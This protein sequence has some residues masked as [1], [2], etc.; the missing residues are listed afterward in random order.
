MPAPSKGPQSPALSNSL[1]CFSL[2][3]DSPMPPS[4]ILAANDAAIE[5]AAESLQRGEL[6]AFPTET[7]YGL[8]ANARSPEAIARVFAAKGR[9]AD[10]PLIV[11]LGGAAELD[12]WAAHVP[13]SAMTL[14][15]AFW[16]GPLTMILRRAEGVSDAITGGQDTVGLRVP[17]H[18]VALR[19]L[20]RFGDGVAAP[21]A[22]RF[23]H[24]SPT[25]AAHVDEG[26][27]PELRL[28]LDGGPCEV[29]IESSIVDL[30]GE[31]PR[32]LRPGMLSRAT[33]EA[34]LGAGFA[35][36]HS[37]APR[38]SGS[39]ASHYA[40]RTPLRWLAMDA[41]QQEL[42]QA[43]PGRAIG[44]IALKDPPPGA[45]AAAW[46]NLSQSPAFY[47]HGLYS[48]L[49]ELD[50]LRLDCILLEIPPDTPEWEGVRDRLR[51]ATS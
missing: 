48:R 14:A 46:R 39:L 51:R 20:R 11:H 7:V 6:V 38:V 24:V 40:P 33:L 28:I 12:S 21:S 8:G 47:A 15:S 9:P 32:L 34:A 27:G 19:L 25:T 2:P 41:I 44:V 37:D 18:P 1:P 13:D 22:N 29:G 4:R 42:E 36:D 35:I 50:A 10:H 31:V 23:G 26:L 30:T 45:S 5:R 43:A 3:A 17:G 49:R 16:P